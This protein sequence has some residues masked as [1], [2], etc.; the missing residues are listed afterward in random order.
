MKNVATSL[1]RRGPNPQFLVFV[2]P[3]W[4]GERRWRWGP[5]VCRLGKDFRSPDLWEPSPGRDPCRG[6]A[7]LL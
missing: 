5:A 3:G 1:A 6:P 7:S 2:A 4:Y